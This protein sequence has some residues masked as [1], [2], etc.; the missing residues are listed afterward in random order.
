MTVPAI[1][2]V[3]LLVGVLAVGLWPARKPPPE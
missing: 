1:I 2:V 3:I